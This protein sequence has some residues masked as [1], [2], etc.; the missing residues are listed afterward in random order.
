MANDEFT[1]QAVGLAT[2]EL[3]ENL[4]QAGRTYEDA[5]RS[6]DPETA[7][8][9]LKAYT[10]AQIA[11]EKLTG[12]GGNQQPQQAELS[13][14]QRNFLS[15]RAAMGDD[16]SPQRM[17]DYARA[18]VRAVAAGWEPDTPQYF[19]AIEGC[20]DSQGDGRQSQ[21]NERSAAEISGITDAEYAANA[22]KL[23]Q[24]KARGYYQD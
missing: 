21:L 19:A 18:H 1:R 6:N 5:A 15:R 9:A 14:A 4:I 22:Q 13:N 17:Q 10:E 24:L 11:Y 20:V 3:E 12:T 23:R 2:R 16:L 7:A 8:Y